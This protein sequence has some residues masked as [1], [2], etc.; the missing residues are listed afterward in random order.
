MNWH[1]VRR[2]ATALSSRLLSLS[3]L[4]QEHEDI[5]SAVVAGQAVEAGNLAR[6]HVEA[7]VGKLK[8]FGEASFGATAPTEAPAVG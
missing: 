2:V 1:H 4:W 6:L 7:T 3:P 8:G 5:L